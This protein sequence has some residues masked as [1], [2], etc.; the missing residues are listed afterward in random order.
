MAPSQRW[1]P[2]T[3]S[4]KL[5]PA[6]DVWRARYCVFITHLFVRVPRG[7]G[8]Q[9]AEEERRGYKTSSSALSL[10]PFSP[11]S[12]LYCFPKLLR[13][14]LGVS[15]GGK[16]SKSP[17]SPALPPLRFSLFSSALSPLYCFPKVL[18]ERLK[19]SWG[20]GERSSTSFYL[21]SNITRVR[22]AMSRPEYFVIGKDRSA[23]LRTAIPMSREREVSNLYQTGFLADSPF[24]PRGLNLFFSFYVPFI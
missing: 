5:R 3:K 4:E 20:R 19:V 18:R 14:C 8:G 15:W 1:A 10:H 22:A 13:E 6:E 23:D 11:F 12:S 24:S 17:H 9:G 21:R 7:K 16:G 2:Y